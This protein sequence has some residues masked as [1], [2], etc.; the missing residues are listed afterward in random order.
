[1]NRR[2]ILANGTVALLLASLA[3]CGPNKFKSY[4]GPLVTQVVVNKGARQMFLL[5]GSTLLRTYRIGL[6]NDPIGHK[7]FEGDGRTPE[8][9]YFIDR[10]NPNSTYHLSIGI[11][12]PNPTDVERAAL[13]GKSAGSDIFIHG[14]GA[15]GKA[16]VTGNWDWTAGCITVSDREVEEIYAMVRDGTPI[17]INP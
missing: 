9:N 16:L 17:Q 10:R 5:S 14:R 3:A 4:N 8:G 15:M 7:Q 2:K 13:V 12:Y 11:S 6:G 1:M